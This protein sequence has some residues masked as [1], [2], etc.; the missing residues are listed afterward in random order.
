MQIKHFKPM[1]VNGGW[2]LFK[3]QRYTFPMSPMPYGHK[4]PPKIRG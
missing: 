2:W 1:F 4:H 3:A